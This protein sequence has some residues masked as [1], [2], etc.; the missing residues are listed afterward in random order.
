MTSAPRLLVVVANG[1][2][3]DSRVQKT[4]IA[5]ARAGWDVTL[6]GAGGRN[7][8]R[9]ETVMGPVRVVRLPM[10]SK[11]A[12]LHTPGPRALPLLLGGKRET[13]RVTHQAWLRQATARI[14][15]LRTGGRGA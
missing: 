12:A 9:S 1:I 3:G 14:G 11:F 6:L 5:A 2:T 10:T 13:N 15:T 7:G 8:R 4:A